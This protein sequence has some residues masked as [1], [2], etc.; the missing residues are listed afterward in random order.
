MTETL[1]ALKC[2]LCIPSQQKNAE[3][4]LGSFYAR[5]QDESL[6]VNMWF[7]L[8]ASANNENALAK[9]ESLIEHEAFDF[10]NPNKL[11]ALV[12]GF[13]QNTSA[14]HH[15]DG[16]GY[17]FL[18]DQI[19]RLNTSNPQIASRLVAPLTHWKKLDEEHGDAMRKALQRIADTDKL[20]KDVYEVVSKSLTV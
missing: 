8:Q 16:S 3:V 18:A 6:V 5:Y 13:T 19:I 14:F 20:S 7:Q 11:R 10:N 9:V 2:L 15:D 4:A 17:E 1:A 12:G